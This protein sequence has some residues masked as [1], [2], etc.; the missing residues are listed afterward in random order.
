MA[1]RSVWCRGSA[2]RLP[3]VNNRKRSFR[4]RAISSGEIVFTRAAEKLPREALLPLVGD[5]ELGAVVVSV[6]L[7]DDELQLIVPGQP[8]DT[9]VPLKDLKFTLKGLTGFSVEFHKDAL[10]AVNEL[11]FFQPNGTF[12]AKRKAVH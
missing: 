6:A 4:R 9:L 3:P 2:V 5:Y 8:I 7:K 1:A 10:G 11:A 12:I